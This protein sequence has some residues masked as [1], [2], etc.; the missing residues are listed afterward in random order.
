MPLDVLAGQVGEKLKGIVVSELDGKTGKK[1]WVRLGVRRKAKGGRFAYVD[2]MVRLNKER[3][4]D[5][6]KV[7]VDKPVTVFVREVRAFRP[8]YCRGVLFLPQRLSLTARRAPSSSFT[9]AQQA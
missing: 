1:A 4:I 5:P 3:G 7:A 2:G 6:R 8:R 9:R